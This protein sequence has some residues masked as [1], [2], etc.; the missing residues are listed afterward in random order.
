MPDDLSDKEFTRSNTFGQDYYASHCG[1]LVY[2]REEPH[3]ARFFGGIADHVVSSLH[4]QRVFDAGCAH[5]F[6]LEALH[7][8]D[9][10]VRGRDISEFAVS[11]VSAKVRPFVEIGSIADPIPGTYDLVTCIEVLEHMTEDEGLNAIAAMAAV[12]PRLL[13]SSSPT[14]FNEPTH[15]NVRPV[16]W[17]LCRFAEAGLVPVAEYDASFVASHAFLLQRSAEAVELVDLLA[18]A[19]VIRCRVLAHER[20]RRFAPVLVPL[21]LPLRYAKTALRGAANRNRFVHRA[22]RVAYRLVIRLVRGASSGSA[23]SRTVKPPH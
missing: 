4:P 8:R 17:W 6:L 21:A 7:D 12:A 11:S 23:I 1:R 19:E 18:F 10:R 2:G 16:I 20:R 14:D 15:I 5:G 9:V 22:S 13:F 3:W